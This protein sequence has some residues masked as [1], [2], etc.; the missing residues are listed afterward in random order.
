[1]T[2]IA[3]WSVR[4]APIILSKLSHMTNTDA[5]QIKRLYRSGDLGPAPDVA[6]EV[7]EIPLYHATALF[8]VQEARKK[9]VAWEAIFEALPA[10]AGAAYI[11]FLLTEIRAGRCVQRGGTPSLNTNLWTRLHSPDVNRDLERKLPGG[12]VETHRYVCFAEGGPVL[13]DD[14]AEAERTDGVIV[15]AWSIPSLMKPAMPGTFLYTHI[16]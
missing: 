6:A 16:P 9:G 13:C 12:A 10:I 11:R 15:D 7:L 5:V 14:L 4:A 2:L 8:V 3:D 1:M